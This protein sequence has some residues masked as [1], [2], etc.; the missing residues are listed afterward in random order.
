[1]ILL[2]SRLSSF[3]IVPS[4]E[5]T[6]ISVLSSSS[7]TIAPAGF[8]IFSARTTAA[9]ESFSKSQII[10]KKSFSRIKSGSA[11]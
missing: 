5:P 9:C 10:G 7:V 11:E 8:K 1:M 6:S 3:S 2:R 4:R